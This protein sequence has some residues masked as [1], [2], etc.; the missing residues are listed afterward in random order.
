MTAEWIWRNGEFVRWDEAT[1]HVS[2]HALHYGS[3]VFEGIRAYDTPKGPAV[4]R[5]REHS[6]RLMH[7]ARIMRIEHENT[8]DSLDVAIVEAIRRNGHASCYIRP[9]IFRGSGRLGIGRA[10]QDQDRDRHLYH[11]MGQVPWR[12]SD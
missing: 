9:I 5:L 3:S 10:G 4:F 1:V 6:E 11:G 7:G 12:R 2:A 8:P